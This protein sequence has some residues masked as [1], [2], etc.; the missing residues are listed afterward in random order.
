MPTETTTR[1]AASSSPPAK[2]SPSARSVA[3]DPPRS[4]LQPDVD[5]QLRQGGPQDARRRRVELALHQAVDEVHDR[6]RAALR[7]D[8]ARGLQPEQPAADH[9]GAPRP[10][11]GRGP[12]GL[13]VLRAAERVHARQV[14][15]RRSA[16]SAAASRWPGPGC[17]RPARS[18]RRARTPRTGARPL[19]RRPSAQLH[20]VVGVPL[21]RAQLAGCAGPRR[22]R[23]SPTG[24]RGRTAGAGLGADQ[25]ERDL[26]CAL[27]H[28][29]QTACPAMPPPTMRIVAHAAWCGRAVSLP[30]VGCFHPMKAWEGRGSAARGRCT[31]DRRSRRTPSRPAWCA[32]PGRRCA[33]RPGGSRPHGAHPDGVAGAQHRGGSSATARRRA[34]RVQQRVGDRS[35]AAQ[36]VGELARRAGVAD[37]HAAGQAVA[38]EHE[39]AVHAAAR[40]AVDDLVLPPATAPAPVPPA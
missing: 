38:V 33:A 2:R 31:L 34:A 10:A 32:R 12:D 19:D 6:D 40:V 37:Q 27:A 3:D 11:R 35:A 5:A 24:E 23:G 4:A 28:A 25:R 7:R 9:G 18:R 17:R 1:S 22:R 20:V 16:A 29:S 36:Q 21:R 14:D 15:A 39:P 30:L 13:A 26:G 8:A